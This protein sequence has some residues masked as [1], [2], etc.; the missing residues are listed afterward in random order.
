MTY[1]EGQGGENRILN[2]FPDHQIPI[3]VALLIFSKLSPQVALVA[4]IVNQAWKV[5]I[6]DPSLPFDTIRGIIQCS[7]KKDLY[8][9]LDFKAPVK[10]EEKLFPYY[11]KAIRSVFFSHKYT[12]IMRPSDS[13]KIM[14]SGYP[15]CGTQTSSS[16]KVRSNADSVSNMVQNYRFAID[17]T[18]TNYAAKALCAVA[19]DEF[20]LTEFTV[21]AHCGFPK[22][23]KG[24][25][26]TIMKIFL[27]N[28]PWK[29]LRRVFL[30]GYFGVETSLLF[31]TKIDELSKLE[32]RGR[33]YQF[34]GKER[35]IHV[36]K[37]E[38]CPW[39]GL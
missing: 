33:S 25:D 29:K 36:I 7:K 15:I 20:N 9:L 38:G 19:T 28:L 24:V 34:F 23:G 27:E 10:W 16:T 11:K 21:M 14:I 22:D 5:L 37:G 31:K 26:D 1:F 35:G 30:F 3:E 12:A 32:G 8:S 2:P 4:A 13:K 39:K 6:L 18:M 17:F